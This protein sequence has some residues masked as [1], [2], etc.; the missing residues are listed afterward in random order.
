MFL[1]R[2]LSKPGAKDDG[3][4]R[5]RGNKRIKSGALMNNLIDGRNIVA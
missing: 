5:E 4:E 3:N 2:F 1:F